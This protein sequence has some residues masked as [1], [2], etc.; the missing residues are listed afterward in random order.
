MP[1]FECSCPIHIHC[2]QN[3]SAARKLSVSHFMYPCILFLSVIEDAHISLVEC[4]YFCFL[5]SLIFHIERSA[6][7]YCSLFSFW[8]TNRQK[9]NTVSTA[10]FKLIIL[11]KKCKYI[12]DLGAVN[13]MNWRS[14]PTLAALSTTSLRDCYTVVV[15]SGTCWHLHGA[16]TNGLRAVM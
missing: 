10:V 16:Y 9:D 3:I 6:I 2:E 1:P 7:V 15:S 4:L 8:S 5:N 14:F 13:M 11:R 12:Q